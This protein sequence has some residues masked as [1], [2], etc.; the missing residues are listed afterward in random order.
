MNFIIENAKKIIEQNGICTGIN[1]DVCP[2]HKKNRD[3]CTDIIEEYRS[4][5]IID[6]K[7]KLFCVDFLKKLNPQLEFVF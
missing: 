4:A 1:C 6:E 5:E 2:L 3:V 7:I